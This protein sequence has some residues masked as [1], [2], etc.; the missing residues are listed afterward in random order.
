MIDSIRLQD[1]IQIMIK[2]E[3]Q[4]DD[5]REWS[6]S[7]GKI[8]ITYSNGKTYSY[9]KNNVQIN[10]SALFNN[11]VLKRFEYLKRIAHTVGLMDSDGKNILANRYDKIDFLC[12]KSMLN[13]FL[14]GT[15]NAEKSII[16]STLIYPFRFNI[17][18]KTAVDNALSNP[19]S[20]IE[21]PPGTGKTQTILNIIANALMNGESV[22]VVSNNN[23]ATA[24]VYEKL[25][26]YDIGFIAAYLGNSD[27]KAKFI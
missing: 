12:E 24:N 10:R 9:N 22:A 18:Q 6:E 20:I 11:T 17:S 7:D 21:G 4:T 14:S 23:S 25:E 19:L 16:Q 27:N 1:K 5:I 15:L 13:V 8:N 3:D 26:K 2:G